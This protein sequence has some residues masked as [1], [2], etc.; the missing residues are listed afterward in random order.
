MKV[1]STINIFLC[2][3]GGAGKYS[4]LNRYMTNEFDQKETKTQGITYASRDLNFF[5]W[6]VELQVWDSSIGRL[7]QGIITQNQIH[8]GCQND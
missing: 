5:T 4:L 2:G 6:H 8:G 1:P 3:A 7:V